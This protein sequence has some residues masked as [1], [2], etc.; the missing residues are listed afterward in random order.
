MDQDGLWLTTALLILILV[1]EY[2]EYCAAGLAPTHPAVCVFP[3]QVSATTP[4]LRVELPLQ[5]EGGQGQG[6]EAH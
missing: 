4:P 3:V 2:C 5:A 6:G 1:Y